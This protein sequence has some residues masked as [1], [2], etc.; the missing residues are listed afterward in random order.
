MIFLLDSNAFS[1]LM[2]KNPRVEA[3][4]VRLGPDDKVVICP[5][6]QRELKV[7][8]FLPEQP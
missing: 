4:L 3:Q 7:K 1:D 6:G 2:R 5:I 8:R